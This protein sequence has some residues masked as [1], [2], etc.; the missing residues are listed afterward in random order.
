MLRNLISR[1]KNR[2]NKLNYSI[3]N[4]SSIDVYSK[5]FSN[6]QIINSSIGKYSYVQSNSI[7]FNSEIGNYCSIANDVK[8]G[9]AEH[10]IH[11]VSTSPVF[12]DPSQPLPKFMADEKVYESCI[13]KTEIQS[14]VWIGAGV[15]I[16]SG[17]IVGTGSIIGA[18]AVVTKDVEPYAIVVGN[19][20]RVLKKRFTEDKVARLLKSEWWN[21]DEAYL[22]QVWKKFSSLEHFLDEIEKPA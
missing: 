15:L 7:L 3:D 14:D 5:I 13:V 21:L 8:I 9:L 2:F 18:G 4:L 17:V 12:Y 6:V 22:K 19:P 1:I 10:P 16:K 11:F 20:A